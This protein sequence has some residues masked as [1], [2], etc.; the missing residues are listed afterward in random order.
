MVTN[1]VQTHD[2]L[3]STNVAITSHSRNGQLALARKVFDEMPQRTVVSWNTI[4]SAYSRRGR[5]KEA[6]NL[7]SS[8]HFT[9]IKLNETTLCS[10]LSACARLPSFYAGKQLHCLLL[11]CGFQNYH[12]VG[13]GLLYFYA[14]C[15]EIE[16][17]R[18]VFD[19]L[20]Q[21][22][23][24]LWSLMLASYVRC[25][26]LDDAL[27]VFDKMPVRDV[28]AWT[29]IISGF[30]KTDGGLEKALEF[31]CVMRRKGEVGPS[32]FTLDCVIR[33]CGRLTASLEGMTVHGLVI[34]YGFEFEHSVS[35][36]LVEFYCACK[37]VDEA[38]SVF[39]SIDNKDPSTY[40]LMI[41]TYSL[42]NRFEDSI[43]LL[44]KMPHKVL[45]SF[46]TMISAYS[47]N[48]DLSKAFEIF[49]SVKEERDIVT[50]NSMISG[51]IHNNQHENALNLYKTMHRLS[52]KQSR[53]TFSSL[54]YACSCLGSLQTGRLLHAQV[55]K[56]PLTCN[57][58]VGTSL[59]DM[60]SKCGRV[61]DA[62]LC[63]ISILNPNVAAHTA[64]INGYALHG[65]CREA[66]LLFE[67]MVNAGVKPNEVTFVGVLSACA[68][69]GW[70]NEGLKYIDQMK[71]RYN[72]MPTIEHFTY[73]VDLL[74]QT[75][76]IREAEELITKMPF[77]PDGVMLGALLKSCWLWFDLEAGQ[78][79][80][81]KM[82]NM[83]PKLVS[84]YVIMSN[85]Y[86]G[87]GRWNEKLEIRRVL[88]DLEV[89]KDPGY[90]WIEVNNEV[91]VFSVDDR[92]HPCYKM[93]FS[94]LMHLTV[95]IHSNMQIDH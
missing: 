13:S 2:D 75:G 51:Y 92:S 62:K 89:K 83:D 37:A 4:I 64:L 32:E 19:V 90:S 80:A 30:S 73:A 79:V 31:F 67:N 52:I 41:K 54:F 18:R 85:M 68:H 49:E 57:V 14:N 48:G 82:V 72:I 29:A 60:Y 24:L 34:K 3:T 25:N 78:R 12:L 53:S 65:M 22:N 16:L 50:W 55:T 44:I 86:C 95:N 58:Y 11:K 76:R 26:M 39:D 70:V 81:R 17:A 15:C 42:V 36:A 10:G 84:A 21:E 88:T 87:F 8:M 5:Y 74:G 59:V 71:E 1:P 47:R 91:F 56:T 20:H 23:Q 46:N 69:A 6:L 43:E 77:D 61:S 66:V 45:T 9:N 63:F 35:D 33:V 27:K 93:I 28:A 7:L 38:E 40:N 94:A